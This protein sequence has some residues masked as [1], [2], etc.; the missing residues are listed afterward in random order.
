MK[1]EQA[2]FTKVLVGLE[3]GDN[4]VLKLTHKAITQDDVL[5]AFNLFAKTKIEVYAFLIVGLPGET[6]ETLLETAR[7][8]KKL[9]RIKYMYYHDVGV[10]MVYPGTEVYRMM[11]QKGLINDDY[12]LTDKPVPYYTVDYTVEELFEFKEILLDH[13]SFERA[14]T[15]RG[16]KAQ[17]R[18]IPAITKFLWSKRKSITQRITGREKWVKYSV[19]REMDT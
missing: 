10:L 14:L 13:I 15:P 1:L 18:M 5:R 6:K 19:K 8:V 11:E 4:R 3:S 9:Q 2:N 17:R 12:W 16:L 7:F